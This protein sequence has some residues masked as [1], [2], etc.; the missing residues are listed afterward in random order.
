[1]FYGRLLSALSALVLF[2]TIAQAQS[3]I[4]S[5][6]PEGLIKTFDL[7]TTQVYQRNQYE[8][9]GIKMDLVY[10][11]DTTVYFPDIVTA[12]GFGTYVRGQVSG[13]TILIKSGQHVFHQDPVY[14]YMELDLYAQPCLKNGSTAN[15]LGDEYIK[16]LRNA[17]GSLSSIGDT[18]IA[19]VD[20]Y[21]DLIG[22]N[23][24]YLFRPFDLL[25]DSV[26]API[27]ISDSACCMSYT[28]NFGNPI[29]RLV[30]LRFASDGVYLQGVSEQRAPQSW[31]H[32]TWDNDKLVFASRQYQG[33]AEVSFLDFIYGGTQDY[34]Q[35]LGYR[36][37]SAIVFDY[38]DG[39]KAFTTSQSLLETYGDKILISSYDAP[40]LTPYTPHEAVPQK[41]GMLGYSD[42]YASSGFDVIRFNIAPVD[43]NGNYIT[44]DSITWR[45]IKD[46]EP[47]TF[48]TDKYHQLSQDQ[49][50]FN[51]GFADN[52]DIVF[53][54][55]GL[56]NIWFYDAWNELQ[57][58][59]T[60]TY[61]GHAHTAISDKMVSTGISLVNSAPKSVSSVSYT[62]LAGRTTNADATGILIKKTT[63]ADGS[64]KVE[65]IIRR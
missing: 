52:I 4:I 51:W 46:G 26:V 15:V 28:D 19:Y 2:S 31:I 1:M 44:P 43:E 25:T 3:D 10:Q 13:D 23:T 36:L 56:Y 55:C 64:T 40:T 57:L 24:D 9:S 30:N 45:L 29:Y 35:S 41:P 39:S 5:A 59:C 60:Y 18:G 22:Y 7:S 65:K 11:G 32:G 34:S 48:T 62:D 58:E 53:E 14:N 20:Q 8:F 61:N 16:F 21:G 42:Y 50:V 12:F 63:F 17:D 6:Q 38:D 37:D 33:V 27:D 54:A 47:Y 49:Q